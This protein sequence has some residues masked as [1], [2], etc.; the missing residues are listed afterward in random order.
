MC[1]KKRA[2]SALRQRLRTKQA[3]I[4]L[5]K[6]SPTVANRD[7]IDMCVPDGAMIWKRFMIGWKEKV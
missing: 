2:N 3:A 7:V 6:K 5:R 4:M 1:S